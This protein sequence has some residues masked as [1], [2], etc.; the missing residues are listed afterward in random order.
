MAELRVSQF[1]QRTELRPALLAV[2]AVPPQELP[3]GLRGETYLQ[4]GYIG[5]DFSTGFIDG[6]ARLDRSLAR[7][8]LGEFR[9]GAGIWGGAQDGA[10]RLDVGPTASLELSIADKPARI[11]IDY[12]HRVAGDARPPSGM[13]VTVST[14]F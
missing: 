2:T 9:A 5:G 10:E 7:F 8:D 6:Q 11:S 14:G 13:A 3:F 1:D 4:A 12:R